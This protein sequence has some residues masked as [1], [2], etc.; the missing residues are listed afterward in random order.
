MNPLPADCENHD[1]FARYGP[2]MPELE[3]LYNLCKGKIG[4]IFSDEPV[5]ELKPIILSNRVKCAA[6]VGVIAP[7]D[8]TVPAGPSGLDPS[9]ISFFH[10]LHI[11]TKI[12]KGQIEILKDVQVSLISF[13][14]KNMKYNHI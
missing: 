2:P 3:A 5:F 4:F 9:Q 6:R 14:Y 1:Y 13:S 8:V 12:N 11:S 10:A 7:I